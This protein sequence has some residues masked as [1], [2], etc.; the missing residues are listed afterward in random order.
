MKRL[1]RIA[2]IAFTL[3]WTA[4]ANDLAYISLDFCDN[5]SVLTYHLQGGQETGLCYKVTNSSA[6]PVK[7]KLGFIDGTFTNDQQQNKA[8][9]GDTDVGNFWKYVTG[10]AHE[11]TISA[12]QTIQQE[13]KLMYEP[14]MEGLYHGCIVYTIV[15]DTTPSRSGLTIIMR[16]ARFIDVLVGNP[17]NDFHWAW[18]VLE[19]F[20]AS[21]GENLSKDPKIRV[22][23]DSAD[24]RY[25]VEIKIK[26]I[27]SVDQEVIITGSISNS[28]WYEEYFVE[29]RKI[30]PEGMVIITKR[31]GDVPPYDLKVQLEINSL[32]FSFD[33]QQAPAASITRE[34]TAI[35]TWKVIGGI[36]IL[37][38]IGVMML[39]SITSHHVKKHRR[40]RAAHHLQKHHIHEQHTPHHEHE[41]HHGTHKHPTKK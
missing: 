39:W 22:Y 2:M 17:K 28:L 7:I 31:L 24:E 19:G 26:N 16:S 15:D 11:L 8:C 27:S 21:D 14:G 18:I 1:V 6:M 25:V 4:K 36:V 32:P 33:T 38:I 34:E 35:G 40:K 29:S 12:G 13:A 30:L 20:T 37:G 5:S 3:L 10:Y 23:K 41:A 9:L